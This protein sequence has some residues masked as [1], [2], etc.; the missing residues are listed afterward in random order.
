MQTSVTP[1]RTDH[2]Q[3]DRKTTTMAQLAMSRI[4][5]AET[6]QEIAECYP[7]IKQLRPHLSLDAFL[8][9]VSELF[10]DGYQLAY[11]KPDTQIVAVAGF[12]YG[13]SLAWGRYLYV[14]DL[15]T[16]E[17]ARSQGFGKQLLDWL[18]AEAKRHDCDQLH[19]DSGVQ[20]KDAHRFYAREG[21]VF[22]SHHY[23]KLL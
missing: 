18:I 16:D 21:M 11:L 2:A 8:Q 14:D 15:I 12:R 5:L 4:F 7:V 23:T 1:D 17:A 13:Q 6:A 9:A 22:S 20:R 3:H 19:L 10:N